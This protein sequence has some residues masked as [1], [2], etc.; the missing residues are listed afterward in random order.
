[1]GLLKWIEEEISNGEYD[2]EEDFCNQNG[3]NYED[4]YDDFDDS[5]D[6][7]GW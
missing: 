2:D 7:F 6:H 5:D 4:I 1:M 3:C